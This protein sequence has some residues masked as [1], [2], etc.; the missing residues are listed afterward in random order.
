MGKLEFDL[1]D[2][3]NFVR[4]GP[5]LRKINVYGYG[6]EY[7][8]TIHF[9]LTLSAQN[10]ARIYEVSGD[11]QKDICSFEYYASSKDFPIPTN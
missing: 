4:T 3:D 7:L 2:A 5:Y 10:I 11:L 8:K 1:G 9:D 6:N